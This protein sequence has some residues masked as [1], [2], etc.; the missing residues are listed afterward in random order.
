VDVEDAVL[1]E[2]RTPLGSGKPGMTKVLIWIKS[3]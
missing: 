2:S 3:Y 1:Y